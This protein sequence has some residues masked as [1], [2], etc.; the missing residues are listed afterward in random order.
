M[1][2]VV[3]GGAGLIGRALRRRLEAAGER[4]I[5]YDLADGHDLRAFEPPAPG[6]ET[7][8]WFL[9]WDVGG[10]K[11]LLDPAVQRASLE[12]NTALCQR[13]FGW[14]EQRRARFLVAGSQMAG[15]P[16]AYGVTKALAHYWTRCLG[17]QLAVLWNVYDAAPVTARSHVI[18]DVIAQALGRG[19]IRLLT[20][21]H[22]RRQ[23]VHGDDCAEA[24]VRQRDG[25]QP[26]A[27]VTSGQWTAV[28]D[29]ARLVAELTGARLV[30]GER[31]GYESIVEPTV[32]LAGWRPVLDL[33]QGLERT[34]AAMRQ[35][36]W[37]L[38]A[39]RC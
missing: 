3:L 29:A 13:V 1:T 16:N 37:G 38:A 7:F 18:P 35:R 34:I 11:F 27:H 31:P 23:L 6:G 26:E 25:G 15:Y 30:L 33:R 9:A 20:D 10:A 4:V 5:S 22:E 8:Y 39:D 19:E 14:L 2:N 12:H 17:G 28:G 32:P 24:L 36:G 21:G